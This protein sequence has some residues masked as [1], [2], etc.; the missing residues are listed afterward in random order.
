MK[1]KRIVTLFVS[2]GLVVIGIVFG[3]I[4]YFYKN[5]SLLSEIPFRLPSQVTNIVSSPLVSVYVHG[6]LCP[7]GRECSS[8]TVIKR[9]GTIIT[10]GE[11]RTVL[12][13]IEL[14]K[15]TNLVNT[16]DY[17]TLK[18]RKYSGLCPT[19]YDGSEAIYTFYTSHGTERIA[20]CEVAIDERAPL[21]SEINQLLSTAQ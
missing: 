17:N 21:F 4:Y 7:N 5:P 9:D 3:V 10:E 14:T 16:E 11:N 8:T 20:S 1:E 12:D 6:G 15:L 13:T 19:S 2:S 18:A